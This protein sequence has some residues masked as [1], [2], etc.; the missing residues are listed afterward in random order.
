MAAATYLGKRWKVRDPAYHGGLGK[1]WAGLSLKGTG[2]T[3]TVA[4]TRAQA[5]GELTMDALSVHRPHGSCQGTLVNILS[6]WVQLS[7]Q[8]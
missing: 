2:Q 7:P 5:L 1:E 4:S 3:I 8:C 6:L